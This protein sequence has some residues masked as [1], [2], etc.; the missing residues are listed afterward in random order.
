MFAG[1]SWWKPAGGTA[2]A[3]VHADWDFLNMRIPSDRIP[4]STSTIFPFFVISVP[5]VRDGRCAGKTADGA[6]CPGWSS[7][8]QD[9]E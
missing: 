6:C 7:D 5:A 2:D 8:R 9:M 4:A 1:D 3:P